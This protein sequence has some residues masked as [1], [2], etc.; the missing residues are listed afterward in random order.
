VIDQA[1]KTLHD[2]SGDLTD[3]GFRR[4]QVPASV[5]GASARGL[6]LGDHHGKA[7]QVIKATLE[8][9]I[10]D[11]EGF[12]DGLRRAEELVC[13]ADDDAADQLARKQAAAELLVHA[14]QHSHGDERNHQ[15]RN[16]YLRGG[17][18]DA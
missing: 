15:A 8:G 1:V 18:D 14:S 12:A 17:G 5:F 7:H 13:S 3:S 9:V 16:E 11:L 2:T 10:L 4:L 6:E